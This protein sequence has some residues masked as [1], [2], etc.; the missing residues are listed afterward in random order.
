MSLSKG[1]LKEQIVLQHKLFQ[2]LKRWLNMALLISSLLFSITL[3]IKQN[4]ILFWIVVVLFTLSIMVTL[5]IGLALKRG[6]DN[7]NK[8]I[9]LLDAK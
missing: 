9:K 6:Q 4:D 8:L 1:E 2:N 7:L 3:F 5:V